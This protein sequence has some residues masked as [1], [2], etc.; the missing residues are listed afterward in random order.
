MKWTQVKLI[1][2]GLCEFSL[3][4]FWVRC[5]SLSVSCCFSGPKRL[6]FLWISCKKHTFI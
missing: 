2:S 6:N 4:L 3:E 1:A 5:R